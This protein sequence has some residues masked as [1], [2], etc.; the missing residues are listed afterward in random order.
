MYYMGH[1]IP[2]LYKN[3]YCLF[4]FVV[5]LYY[6]P[7]LNVDEQ[8][9]YSR[10]VTLWIVWITLIRLHNCDLAPSHAYVIW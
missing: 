4:S 10:M 7:I 1:V 8:H 2:E 9:V 6:V 5:L 3:N